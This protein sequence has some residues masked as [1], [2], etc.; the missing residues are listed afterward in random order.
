VVVVG[1]DVFGDS[2]VEDDH[3]MVEADL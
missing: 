2:V 1:R 3:D